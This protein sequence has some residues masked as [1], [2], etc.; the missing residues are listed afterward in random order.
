MP[1]SGISSRVA[2]AFLT[3]TGGLQAAS[4]Q[5]K[6]ELPRTAKN[7]SQP[8]P[9]PPPN[10]PPAQPPFGLAQ[11]L[12]AVD[13]GPNPPPASAISLPLFACASQSILLSIIPHPLRINSPCLINH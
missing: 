9:P 4:P 1:C 3:N 2:S 13:S 10:P 12:L 6:S 7:T 8:Q 11:R 5:E